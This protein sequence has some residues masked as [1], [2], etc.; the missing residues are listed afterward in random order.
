MKD[1]L[2]LNVVDRIVTITF[3]IILYSVHVTLNVITCA[4]CHDIFGSNP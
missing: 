4:Q 3:I 2:D 1:L